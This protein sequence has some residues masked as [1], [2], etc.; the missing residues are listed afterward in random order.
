MKIEELLAQLEGI[1]NVLQR[2]SANSIGTDKDVTCLVIGSKGEVDI[3]MT[4]WGMDRAKKTYP[5]AQ[6]HV[7]PAG[8]WEGAG[9]RTSI[10][11]DGVEVHE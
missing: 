6:L 4:P 1:E 5:E 3:N 11:L 8:D 7:K 9:I 2:I 10:Y